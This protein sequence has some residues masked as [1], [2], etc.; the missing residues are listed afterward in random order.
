MENNTIDRLKKC[1][2]A[3]NIDFHYFEDKAELILSIVEAAKKADSIGIGNSQT[4]KKLRI[5]ETVSEY[6]Q[7]V[8]DKTL[9]GSKEEEVKLKRQ[10]LLTDLYITSSNAITADGRIINVDHSGNRVAAMTFG[11]RQVI[12]IIGEN[13][14]TENEQEGILRS[15]K[16]ATPLNARRAKYSPPCT[17]NRPCA[18][19]LQNQRVC[20]YL[21]I[22]RGQVHPQRM[23][24]MM[25]KGNYGY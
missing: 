13:K 21:S 18:E 15:L 25:L 20:N 24:V 9:A 22:I 7:H 11:P 14:L 8:Y 12:I 23:S 4:L 6:C 5:F 1:F 2:K 10:A 19:C 17:Q 3:R 16:V